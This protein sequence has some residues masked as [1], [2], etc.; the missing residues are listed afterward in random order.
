[1]KL[2]G[3]AKSSIVPEDNG[4]L[5][6]DGE[7]ESQSD[8][9]VINS[10]EEGTPGS[11][12]R[13]SSQNTPSA[14]GSHVSKSLSG[15]S[16]RQAKNR[17]HITGWLSAYSGC[18]KGHGERL[19]N[20]IYMRK[21]HDC[22]VK[23]NSG[24]MEL[25]LTAPPCFCS[26]QAV[27]LSNFLIGNRGVQGLWPLL[28]YARALKALN[29]A[30]N[31]IKDFGMRHIISIFNGDFYQEK[32]N[33]VAGLLVL[34]LSNNPITGACAEELSR[35]YDKRK[36]ILM[37]GMANT[38]LPSIRR[39]RLL[40]SCLAKTAGSSPD[41]I[42]EAWRLT[43]VRDSFYD[44]ELFLQ[45]ERIVEATHGTGIHDII[46]ESFAGKSRRHV[47]WNNETWDADQDG[48]SEIDEDELKNWGEYEV[49]RPSPGLS[50]RETPMTPDEF[51][52]PDAPS[53]S[54]RPDSEES[55]R[56]S[57]ACRSS[58]DG[59]LSP[60]FV[61]T[62][63]PFANAKGDDDSCWASRRRRAQFGAR[64]KSR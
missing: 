41:L 6:D 53:Y 42:L 4:D 19:M 52:D 37:L 24:V 1:M 32:N 31:G 54:G 63:N 44:R 9:E 62:K 26:L 13:G 30:G 17:A 11:S 55:T 51:V 56:P 60:S 3:A 12:L 64:C 45:F 40:R 38:E 43:Q 7:I 21:C 18:T 15:L 20:K 28:R 36:D 48:N 34:D 47:S 23:M 8:D 57:T 10:D 39:Q 27:N 29:L 5:S 46:G 14:G 49:P 25:L 58:L 35:F 61:E 33:E 2:T 59:L 16:A 22:N 50:G